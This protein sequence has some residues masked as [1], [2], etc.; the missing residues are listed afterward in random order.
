MLSIQVNFHCYM[1]QNNENDVYNATSSRLSRTALTPE[2]GCLTAFSLAL[3][4][5]TVLVTHC[6]DNQANI[7][8]MFYTYQLDSLALWLYP[9]TIRGFVQRIDGY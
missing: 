9:I 3:S 2:H 6:N 5:T 1:D 8:N 7:Y 4:C